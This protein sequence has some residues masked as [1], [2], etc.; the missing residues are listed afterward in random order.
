MAMAKKQNQIGQVVTPVVVL[1]GNL[2]INFS[3][4]GQKFTDVFLCGPAEKVFEGEINL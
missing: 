3:Y 4:D 1:G 2:E